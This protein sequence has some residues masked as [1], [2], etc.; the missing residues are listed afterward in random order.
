M[1]FFDDF[2]GKVALDKQALAHKDSELARL[3]RK[4]RSSPNAR[5]ALTTRAYIFEEA[6]RVS[7]HLA[8]QHLDV[9]KYVLDVSTYTRR[10]KAR[11]LY[12][13]LVIADTPK[14]H[15]K[16]LISS[17]KIPKIVDHK[18]Y[19]PRIVEWMTDGFRVSDFAAEKYAGAFL[20]ALR[21]PKQL[22]DT[23]FRTHIDHKCRHLLCA[24]FFCPEYGEQMG[25]L[26]DSFDSLHTV[27]CDR[28][29][30]QR[31]PKDFEEA[32]RILEG[33]FIDIRDGDVS[34]VNP[35]VRDYLA[36]YLED[37]SLLLDFASSACKIGWA[38][39]L[40][41]FGSQQMLQ[42]NE[43]R[44]F[45]TAFL[46]IAAQVGKLP[47]WRQSGTELGIFEL[48]SADLSNSDRIS[49]LL[50]WWY[51]TENQRFADIL[52]ELMTAPADSFGSRRDGT[53]LVRLLVEIQDPDYGEG[54]PYKDEFVEFLEAALIDVLSR[55]SI[56][57]LDGISDAVDAAKS[58]IS[59][60]IATAVEKAV[61]EQ[62]DDID[63]FIDSEEPESTLW[64][65]ISTLEKWASRFAIPKTV[66]SSAVSKI[67][68][69]IAMIEDDS[70][71]F[72]SPSF[73]TSTDVSDEF[74]DEA[75]NNLFAPLLSE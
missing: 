17:G 40:W 42:P 71:E 25:E 47:A 66:L 8:D 37:I 75:L 51:V 11:I 64:D 20:A 49:L 73:G 65:C 26:R 54:F 74:D 23:A 28:Y 70:P 7:E 45:A 19:N 67:E 5:F 21:N 62:F 3:V 36:E 38:Q 31:S 1:F 44:K 22:W 12:N 9:S 14:E 58:A 15:V 60:V 30:L 24:L 41:K 63:Y 56:D 29:R 13:H 69:R 27:L 59:P 33:S 34:Y 32:I 68:E 55:V 48:E 18:N 50:A 39:S 43:Q 4:V 16:A 6:R 52:R 10:I 46:P 35:S 57:V 72:E 53:D 2:L 61:L